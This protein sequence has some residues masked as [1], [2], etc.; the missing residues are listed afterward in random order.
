MAGVIGHK[1]LAPS[2]IG[3]E[4]QAPGSCGNPGRRGV[5]RA[6]S[7]AGCVPDPPFCWYWRHAEPGRRDPA[8]TI[9]LYLPITRMVASLAT[10]AP[11][12]KLMAFTTPEAGAGRLF[13]IFMASRTQ[14]RSPFFTVSPTLTE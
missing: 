3:F 5:R 1:P 12:S 10:E 9:N 14:I 6:G 13:C 2:L 4:D 8:P 11:G 7:R